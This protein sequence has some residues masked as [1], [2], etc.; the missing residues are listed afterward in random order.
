MEI[1]IALLTVAVVA[2]LAVLLTPSKKPVIGTT[3]RYQLQHGQVQDAEFEENPVAAQTGLVLANPRTLALCAPAA[4]PCTR[5]R[6]VQ[7]YL[8]TDP[9]R[10]WLGL[11]HSNR[12]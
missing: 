6:A 9:V 8:N 1:L 5:Q 4:D 3:I 2:C 10:P 7:A 11:V 12:A